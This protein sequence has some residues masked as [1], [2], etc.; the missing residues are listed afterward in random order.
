VY[1]DGCQRHG[2]ALVG[3]SQLPVPLGTV[4]DDGAF[5]LSGGVVM[6]GIKMS[7]SVIARKQK[8]HKERNK[9][10]E[11]TYEFITSPGMRRACD[12]WTS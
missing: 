6:A 2:Q 9:D 3:S 10:G 1:E 8:R 12:K 7:I 11:A 4:R 5:Y